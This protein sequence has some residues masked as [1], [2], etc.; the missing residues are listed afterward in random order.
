MVISFR[1]T[2]NLFLGEKLDMLSHRKKWTKGCSLEKMNSL[3]VFDSIFR[4][5]SKFAAIANKKENSS[6]YHLCH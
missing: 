4:Q 5:K 3:L 1:L 6:S 2:E